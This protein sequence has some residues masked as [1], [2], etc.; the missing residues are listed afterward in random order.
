MGVGLGLVAELELRA[1]PELRLVR[2]WELGLDLGMGR[3][4]GV[5]LGLVTGLELRTRPELRL[6]RGWELW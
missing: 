1:R 2:G 5:G 3:G 4:L 6:E